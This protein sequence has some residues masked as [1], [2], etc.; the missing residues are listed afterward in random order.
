V[1]LPPRQAAWTLKIL[2]I[3]ANSGATA[4]FQIL[5]DNKGAGLMFETEGDTL[6]QTFKSEHGNF[7]ARRMQ[8]NLFEFSRA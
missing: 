1:K 7:C 2:I 8:S 3:L 5:N 4:F 6:V